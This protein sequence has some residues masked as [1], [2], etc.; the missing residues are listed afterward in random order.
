MLRTLKVSLMPALEGIEHTWHIKDNGSEDGTVQEA[1]TWGP[2]V[3]VYEYP[4]NRQNFAEGMN[5]IFNQAAPEDNDVVMLLNNDVVLQDTGSIQAMLDCLDDR[6]CVVGARLMFTNEPKKLQHAGVYFP[7]HKGGMPWHFRAGETVD[8]HAKQNRYFQ[9]VTGAVLMTRAGDYRNVWTQ[10]KSGIGGM[11]E[12]YQWAF[13]DIDLCLAI[14]KATAKNVIYCGATNILHA[15]SV[16]LLKN[17]V[18]RLFMSSNVKH[19]RSKWADKYI[20]DSESYEKDPN[21]GLQEKTSHENIVAS[22][23]NSTST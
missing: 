20:V 6:T 19:F 18:N 3:R 2:N 1:R 23:N 21:Y 8:D 22:T 10:N 12:K 17:P 5:Y 11:D 9:S 4:N 16:T 13:E 7:T 14:R 15:E